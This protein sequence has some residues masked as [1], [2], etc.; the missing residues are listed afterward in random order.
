M[1]LRRLLWGL[2]IGLLLAG[3]SAAAMAEPVYRWTDDRGVR[4]FSG[5]PP[6]DVGA[7]QVKLQPIS[8]VS[9]P[10]SVSAGEASVL[11]EC[12]P[13]YSGDEV[14]EPGQQRRTQGSESEAALPQD[15]SA[16]TQKRGAV[17]DDTLESRTEKLVDY[18]EK[19]QMADYDKRKRIEEIEKEREIRKVRRLTPGERK[20]KDP[21]MDPDTD[22]DTDTDTVRRIPKTVNEKLR[23]KKRRQDVE[24]AGRQK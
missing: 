14:C 8:V 12:E 7:E 5:V 11:P 15:R 2:C 24:Q 21:D 23:E 6:K 17:R 20:L 13:G 3:L 10:R 19:K 1:V 18:N 4:H 16:A 22:T 9:I